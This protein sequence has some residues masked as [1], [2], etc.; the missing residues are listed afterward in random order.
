MTFGNPYAPPLND[1]FDDGPR[2]ATAGVKLVGDTLICDKGASLPRVCLFSGE[3]SSE[4]VSRTLSWAPQWFLIL[5]AMS[6]L[7]GALLYFV[8]RKTARLEYSL[9]P[10]ARARSSS[11]LLIAIGGGVGGFLLA[12]MAGVADQPLLA[13]L[14]IVIALIAIVVGSVRSRLFTI[15]KIDKQQIHL[16]LRPDALRG[17]ERHFAGAS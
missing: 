4:R 17:F 16:K 1:E 15:T 6:P 2:G 11:S 9:T 8:I 10:S 14:L 13:L 12:I 7:L 3:P 5:A